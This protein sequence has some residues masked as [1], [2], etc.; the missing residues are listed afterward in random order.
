MSTMI[1]CGWELKLR[2]Q[3]QSRVLTWDRTGPGH[4]RKSGAADLQIAIQHRQRLPP[5]KYRPATY[6]LLGQAG[7]GQ[8]TFLGSWQGP[9]KETHHQFPFSNQASLRPKEKHELSKWVHE[10]LGVSLIRDEDY[11]KLLLSERMVSIHVGGSATRELYRCDEKTLTKSRLNLRKSVRVA[12]PTAAG[13]VFKVSHGV[14]NTLHSSTSQTR[15]ALDEASDEVQFSGVKS[16]VSGTVG[17]AVPQRC[18][19]IS[20]I[21]LAIGGAK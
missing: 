18:H 8:I 6:E 10:V 16:T 15:E 13:T 4:I 9:L 7:Q 20:S 17:D 11:Y 5:Q 14:V 19:G 21:L 2:D 12:E 1:V 3:S